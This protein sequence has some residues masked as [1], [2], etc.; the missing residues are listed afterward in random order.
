VFFKYTFQALSK[1]QVVLEEFNI[2][3]LACQ[4]LE[5]IQPV[6][7]RKEIDSAVLN[8]MAKLG[9]EYPG[10][11]IG[12]GI[13][14]DDI[15]LSGI[16][17]LPEHKG[18]SIS[19]IHRDYMVKIPLDPDTDKGPYNSFHYKPDDD[20]SSDTYLQPESLCAFTEVLKQFNKKCTGAGCQVQFGNFYHSPSWKTHKTHGSGHCVDIRPQRKNS[21]LDISLN[22]N[23]TNTGRYSR[24]KTRDLVDILVKAGG[25]PIFFND[26]KIKGVTPLARHSNHI[27]VCFKPERQKVKDACRKGL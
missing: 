8:I 22:Y 11:G 10:F 14:T 21:D 3:P 17:Y 19:R 24:E 25:S 13:E 4:L 12:E 15:K 7:K 5:H 2:N 9:E 18:S 6:P 26:K 20:N 27:H 23:T 16:R 1:D